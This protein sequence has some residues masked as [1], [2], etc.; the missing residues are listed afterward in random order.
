M[1]ENMM[2]HMKKSIIRAGDTVRIINPE[3]FVRCGYELTPEV[4]R[5]SVHEKHGDM[6]VDFIRDFNGTKGLLD[7]G[8]SIKY[9]KLYLELVDV[10]SYEW[11]RTHL[12]D[13][14]PR[15]LYTRPAMMYE[16]YKSKVISMK[17]VR[18]GTYHIGYCR[19]SYCDEEVDYCPAYLDAIKVHKILC[20]VS[21]D[22]IEDINVEKVEK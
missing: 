20:L 7:L 8:D 17:Y 21:G 16:R 13:G 22:M 1:K 19:S 6:I 10:M 9:S 12:K 15:S 4:A 3:M 14:V 2:K 18:T 11:I 5:L